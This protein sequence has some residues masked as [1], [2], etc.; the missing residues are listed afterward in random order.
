[1]NDERELLELAAR[2]YGIELHW[3]DGYPM[4]I[5]SVWSGDPND[6]PQQ[7]DFDWNP[8]TN[9][10]DANAL[11]ERLRINVIWDGEEWFAYNEASNSFDPD[12]LRAITLCAAEIGRKMK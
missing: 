12:M 4:G 5:E 7:R 8:L 3:N 9:R 1:M 2:A 11:H 10:A 6:E